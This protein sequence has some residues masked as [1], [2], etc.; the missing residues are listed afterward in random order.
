MKEITIQIPDGK[1]AEYKEVDGKMVIEI[2]DETPVTER[3]KTFSDALREVGIKESVEEWEKKYA[4]LE[5]DVVAYMKLR[6]ITDALNEGHKPRIVKGAKLYSP[7][8]DF[9]AGEEE[10][11]IPLLVWSGASSHKFVQETTMLVLA[12][13]FCSV[14]V[15]L[16]TML[17]YISLKFGQITCCHKSLNRTIR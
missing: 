13:A 15:R 14:Q 2:V 16:L 4:N 5:K 6:I 1:I 9:I 10:V 11:G 8:F 12:H 7:L 17:E 3:V